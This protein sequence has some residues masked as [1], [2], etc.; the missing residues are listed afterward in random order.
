MAAS[1]PVLGPFSLLGENIL[2]KYRVIHKE[3]DFDENS[4]NMVLCPGFSLRYFSKYVDNEKKKFTAVEN[5]F[6]TVVTEVSFLVGNPV[7][8]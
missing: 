4:S 2:Y 1:W 5:Q 7:D 6:R 8:I 3:W